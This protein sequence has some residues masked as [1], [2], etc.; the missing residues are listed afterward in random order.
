MQIIHTKYYKLRKKILGFSVVILLIL[1]FLGAFISDYLVK[2]N[3]LKIDSGIIKYTLLNTYPEYERYGIIY[4]NCLDIIL[5]NKP[6]YIRLTDELN[7]KHWIEINDK[8]NFSKTIQVKFQSRL[9]QENVLYNP[10]QLSI[11]N[12]II[13]PWDSDK[14]FIEWTIVFA[15]IVLAVSVYYFSKLLNQYKEQLYFQDKQTGQESKW[16]L[17]S[18]WIND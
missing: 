15:I 16:K 3:D 4:K 6:Y 13:I 8:R 12:R 2:E 10:N 18:T 11:D 9:L 5:A 14:N 1:V 17:I 7:N